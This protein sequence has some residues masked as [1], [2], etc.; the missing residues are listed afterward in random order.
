MFASLGSPYPT[1]G[2]CLKLQSTHPDLP[3]PVY[4]YFNCIAVG[5]TVE[6]REAGWLSTTT[7]CSAVM[8]HVRS[9]LPYLI[10]ESILA[11]MD[12]TF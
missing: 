11:G 5:E 1:C 6:K 4:M 2:L 10:G 3:T 12:S 7:A 8:S 9:S